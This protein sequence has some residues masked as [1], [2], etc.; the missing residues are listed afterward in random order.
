MRI[1]EKLRNRLFWRSRCQM[2]R[3]YCIVL[4]EREAL[5]VDND[6]HDNDEVYFKA[7]DREIG[8]V[9]DEMRNFGFEV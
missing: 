7:L 2:W 4:S 9:K 1:L 8:E 6:S 5:R 3:L